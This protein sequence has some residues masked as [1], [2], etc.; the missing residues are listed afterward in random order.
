MTFGELGKFLGA[1][2]KYVSLLLALCSL[3]S[4][5]CSLF[6]SLCSLPYALIVSP[7]PLSCPSTLLLIV[8]TLPREMT[9]KDKTNY[10]EEAKQDK[11][12]DKKI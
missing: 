1:K 11:V 5:L 9:V 10:T 8:T 7:L 3:L 2:W 4:A 12:L 6:S